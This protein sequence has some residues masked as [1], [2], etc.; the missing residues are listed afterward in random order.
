MVRSE[1]IMGRFFDLDSPFMRV[2]N[3]VADLMILNLLMIVCCIPVITIGASVTAM[4]YVLL[5]MIRGEDGYLIRGFFKSF[6]ENFK[7]ATLI[8][9]LLLVVIAVYIGDAV[10]FSFSGI[11]FPKPLVIAVA[12]VGVVIFLIAMYVFPLL[13]R[14]ENSIRN[15]IKNAALIAIGNL[16][17]T[18]LMA[19][20]YVL[21][22][23]IS[24]FSTYAMLFVF[25]FGISAPAFGAAWLYSN[26]FKKFEPEVEMVSDMDF[27]VDMGE[28]SEEISG[29]S[30]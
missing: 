27:T 28:K 15:T 6:K 1:A 17:K 13:A 10:I 7:Q 19:I 12:A 5:K 30:E 20:F 22:L 29:E 14:F 24:Y 23:V 8:W 2:L 11:V 9:L 25:L 16:P 4:H 18:I 21:P 3:R 26:I